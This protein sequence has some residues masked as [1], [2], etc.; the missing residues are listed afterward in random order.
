MMVERW[1]AEPGIR[2]RRTSSVALLVPRVC[3]KYGCWPDVRRTINEQSRAGL[4]EDRIF[5]CARMVRAD[6][7]VA[8]QF[9]SKLSLLILSL[10]RGWGIRDQ[11]RRMAFAL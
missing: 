10:M 2:E 11:P 4:A 9:G 3:S 7:D 5:V 1:I 6:S 8:S